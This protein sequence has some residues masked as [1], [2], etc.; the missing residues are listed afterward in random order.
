MSSQKVSFQLSCRPLCV[1][2][3]SY[4][5]SLGPSFLYTE[6]PKFS[7]TVLMTLIIF[8][9]SSGLSLG[10]PHPSNAGI[11]RDGC[12]ASDGFHKI[13]IEEENNFL[14]MLLLT[15][16]RTCLAF[17]VVS[18]HLAHVQLLIL[19]HLQ[20]LL[21]R[22]VLSPFSTQPLFVLEIDLNYT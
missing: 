6:Q 3:S 18:A 1:L 2:E 12:S 4:E 16:P 11:P 5:I 22:N 13:W 10:D 9:L 7:Q 17:W 8:G 21:I 14:P 15:Q 19:Q 20:V